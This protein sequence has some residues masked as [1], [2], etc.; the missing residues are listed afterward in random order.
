[1]LFGEGEERKLGQVVFKRK[2]VREILVSDKM[3]DEI[4]VVLHEIE[5]QQR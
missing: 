5:A 4:K 1:M 3:S 2:H